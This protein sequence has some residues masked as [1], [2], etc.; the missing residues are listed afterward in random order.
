[1][2]PQ[3]GLVLEAGGI[4]LRI[5]YRRSQGD[6]G[7]TFHIY[8]KTPEAEVLRFDCFKKNPHYHYYAPEGKNEV[9]AMDKS[10]IPIPLEW[11]VTQLKTRLAAMI[12]HAG[13]DA[14]A[15]AVD[16]EAVAKA[17]S[18]S[19]KEIKGLEPSA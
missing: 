15:V 19:E 8:R 2:K 11:T 4:Q 3:D 18:D 10:E 16:Q 12:E 1:M 7:W 13:Y 5:E 14:S 17:L 9:H 6:E